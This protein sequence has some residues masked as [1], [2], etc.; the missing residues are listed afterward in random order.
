MSEFCDGAAIEEVSSYIPVRSRLTRSDWNDREQQRVEAEL[1]PSRITQRLLELSKRLL[2]APAQGKEILAKIYSNYHVLLAD[3]YF[4]YS[5][6]TKRVK[7]APKIKL[8]N[9]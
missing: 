4:K 8:P 5:K 3:E 2:R 6:D 7:N 1:V 9:D